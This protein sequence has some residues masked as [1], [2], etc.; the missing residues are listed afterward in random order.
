MVS[1]PRV[2]TPTHVWRRIPYEAPPVPPAEL[3]FNA[4]LPTPYLVHP[5]IID[6]GEQTASGVANAT[7]ISNVNDTCVKRILDPIFVASGDCGL[8]SRTDAF[9]H[10]LVEVLGQ[11][12]P[13]I[14]RSDPP[15]ETAMINRPDVAISIPPYPA[16][17]FIREK[18]DNAELWTSIDRLKD[19]VAPI[20]QYGNLPFVVLIAITRDLIMFT[21]Q[22][23]VRGGMV[24]PVMTLNL[25]SFDNRLHAIRAFINVGRWCNGVVQH[26]QTLQIARITKPFNTVIVRR[27]GAKKILLAPTGVQVTYLDDLPH[28]VSFYQAT[29]GCPY[30][31]KRVGR[32]IDYK[33]GRMCFKL[34]PIG[35]PGDPNDP[36]ELREGVRVRVRVRV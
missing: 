8:I 12:L 31:E 26:I 3:N 34:V 5:G 22:P 16:F 23:L 28:L 24:P 32:G 19:I 17:V 30:L 13:C 35:S 27:E 18:E 20:P 21:A 9:L 10:I 4:P 14:A 1:R 7:T 6:V 36:T 25:V 33:F 15:E 2:E 11:N 29:S